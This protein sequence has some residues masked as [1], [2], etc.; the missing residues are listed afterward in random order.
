VVL[1]LPRG[2]VVVAA[3]VARALGAPLDVVVVRKLGV[4]GHRE[5]A[6][7]AIGE[8]GVRVVDDD[9]VRLIGLRPGE[10]AGVEAEERAALDRRVTDLRGGTPPLPLL[11]R[12]VIVVDDGVATGATAA[13]ACHV[14]RARWPSRL[15]LATPVA[16]AGWAAR[17][18]GVVDEA[19]AV[20][21]PADLSSVGEWYDDFTQT[22]DDEVLRAIEELRPS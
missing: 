2:G 1:G 11:G 14:V 16:P 3:E 8:G 12:R 19:V 21:E 6:M 5:L 17:F 7:G 13:A 22:T 9:V 10:L 15:V 18:E 4:P 20:V